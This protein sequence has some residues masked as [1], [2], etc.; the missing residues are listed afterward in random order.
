MCCYVIIFVDRP[1]LCEYC[2][3]TI[4]ENFIDVNCWEKIS[5]SKMFNSNMLGDDLLI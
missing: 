4:T 1:H 2:K 3:E 5:K